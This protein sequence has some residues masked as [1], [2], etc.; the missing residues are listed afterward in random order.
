[1]RVRPVDRIPFG[2]DDRTLEDDANDARQAATQ[3]PTVPLRAVNRRREVLRIGRRPPLNT[4]MG[5]HQGNIAPGVTA[6]TGRTRH[7]WRSVPPS[8]DK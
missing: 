6:P 3:E 2:A 7:R 5:S 8:S 4:T 1:M